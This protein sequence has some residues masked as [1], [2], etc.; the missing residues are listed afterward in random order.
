PA[1]A[2]GLRLP[3]AL[4]RPLP[5]LHALLVDRDDERRSERMMSKTARW[6]IL[7]VLVLSAGAL[8]YAFASGSGSAARSGA[9]AECPIHAMFAAWFHRNAP[10]A[11]AAGPATFI[12]AFAGAMRD[13][14]VRVEVRT[15]SDGVL[16]KFTGRDQAAVH[17]V[18]ERMKEFAAGRTRWLAASA[19][20]AAGT[21]AGAKRQSDC[22]ANCP[23]S[24]AA[25]VTVK[26]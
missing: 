12:P 17:R 16:V 1:P 5:F 19:T 8:S 10:P 6:A 18:Q 26:K 4:A 23:L 14:G 11:A 13:E 15:A 22:D 2:P 3:P 21:S 25:S 24:G 9:G 7:G 20:S